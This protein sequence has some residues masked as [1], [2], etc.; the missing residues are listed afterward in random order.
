MHDCA[1]MPS[2]ARGVHTIIM[3]VDQ[4]LRRRVL[5]PS[6]QQ[7]AGHPQVIVMPVVAKFVHR[8]KKDQSRH[9]AT[10]CQQAKEPSTAS[11]QGSVQRFWPRLPCGLV[12]TARRTNP[13]RGAR[14]CPPFRAEMPG[15]ARN[16]AVE[17]GKSNSFNLCMQLL[18]CRVDECLRSPVLVLTHVFL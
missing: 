9:A 11:A 17:H 2:S 6:R 18:F 1:S 14:Q 3:P 4:V 8:T 12:R 5:S 15:E 16:I 7:T 10:D 13:S